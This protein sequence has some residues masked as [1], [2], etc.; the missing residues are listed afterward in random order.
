MS[1]A[2]VERDTIIVIKAAVTSIIAVKPSS[3]VLEVSF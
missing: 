2:R 1:L 3:N